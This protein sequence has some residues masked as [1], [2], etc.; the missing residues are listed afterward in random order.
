MKL[1]HRAKKSIAE[2]AEAIRGEIQAAVQ[3]G[4]RGSFHSTVKHC[5]VLWVEKWRETA[6][7]ERVAVAS[8]VS[9]A[10]CVGKRR[11]G[12]PETRE[13]TWNRVKRDNLCRL[14]QGG[15]WGQRW[16]CP[17][18]CSPW[19][20]TSACLAV[21]RAANG[22]F[23]RSELMFGRAEGLVNAPCRV[24]LGASSIQFRVRDEISSSH[25]C[26][27]ADSGRF[28]WRFRRIQ[29]TFRKFVKDFLHYSPF[30]ALEKQLFLHIFCELIRNGFTG[31]FLNFYWGIPLKFKGIP[32]IH[33]QLCSLFQVEQMV[34]KFKVIHWIGS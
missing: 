15:Q 26:S 23:L 24:R 4:A 18:A 7:V 22:F 8:W 5:N 20:P 12:R 33:S 17:V 1:A 14:V 16:R 2:W 31:E 11:R 9:E 10:E 25:F 21:Q 28:E 34:W 30:L 27:N 19:G 6:K 13:L 29:R 32:Q 3:C